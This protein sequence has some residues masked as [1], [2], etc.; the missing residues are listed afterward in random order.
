[1]RSRNASSSAVFSR[2]SAS[3]PRDSTLSRTS[4][5]VL[6]ARTLKRQSLEFHRQ[7]VGVIDD[8]G[9]LAVFRLGLDEHLLRIRQ[10][11]IDLA[12]R[13]ECLDA[14]RDQLVERLARLAHALE[15][16]QPGNHAAVAIG[17]IAEVVMRAHLAAVGAIDLAHL[18]LDESVAGLAHDRHAAEPLHGVDGVPGE[19][20]VV[21]DARAG[22][23]GEE[24]LGQQPDDVV[25]LDERTLR[26]VE[27]AAV[28]VAVPGDADVGAGLAQRLE[29]RARDSP[30]ASGWARLAGT[31]RSAR[32]AP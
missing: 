1:M 25:A 12:A 15:H 19:A 3:L 17:E 9:A 5:S 32:A 2:I 24:R 8:L 23:F 26:V 22:L 29:R 10:L 16:Q 27:E 6:E 20:R 7:S 18:L 28:V 30:R 31:C 11:A 13:R 14:R 21:D 4:G